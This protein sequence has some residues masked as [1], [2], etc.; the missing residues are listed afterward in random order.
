LFYQVNSRRVTLREYTFEGSFLLKPL[1]AFIGVITKLLRVRLPSSVDIPPVDSMARFQID[2]GELAPELLSEL[3]LTSQA[4]ESLGFTK[5]A[6][7]GLFD[8]IHNTRYASQLYF[9][10]GGDSI[11]WVRLRRWPQLTQASRTVRVSLMTLKGNELV[12]LT[13]S[14]NRDLLDP[15]A[16]KVRYLTRAPIQELWNAHREH[17]REVLGSS[18][19]D[20]AYESSDAIELLERSHQQHVEFQRSRGVFEFVPES[21]QPFGASIAN[22]SD[23]N[24][25]SHTDPSLQT[26]P[27]SQTEPSKQI[28]PYSHTDQ[29]TP[30]IEAVRASENRQTHRF[31]KLLVLVASVVLFIGLG[32][33]NWD[34]SLLLMLVPILFVHE[35]GHFIAMR[36]F[37]YRNVQMFFIPLFGA[38]VTG[39]HYNVAAWKKAMVSLAGPTP[40][41]VLAIGLGALAFFMDSELLYKT[42]GFALIINGLNLLPFLPLDGGWLAHIT[43]FSRS[44]KLDLLFRLFT[45]C[46]LFSLWYLLSDRFM[47]FIGIAM[48]MGLPV[49]WR[50]MRVTDSLRG[51][52]L[53]APVNDE[54]PDE[55][56]RK[57]ASAVQKEGVPATGVKQLAMT[58]INVY[59]SLSSP[60]PSW[61]ATLGIWCL[62]AGSL[63]LAVIG[64]AV[65]MTAYTLRFSDL[66]DLPDATEK[67]I[68]VTLNSGQLQRGSLPLAD[69]ENDLMLWQFENVEA[70]TVGFEKLASESQHTTARVDNLVFS[71]QRSKVD[72]TEI[73]ASEDQADEIL[74][75][76][77]MSGK[78]E[79]YAHERSAR[80]DPRLNVLSENVVFKRLFDSPVSSYPSIVYSFSDNDKADSIAKTLRS[81]PL[82]LEERR[83][84]PPWMPGRKLTP[85][86]VQLQ[87]L[88]GILSGCSGETPWSNQD[89]ASSESAADDALFEEDLDPE[90][91]RAMVERARIQEEQRA[92][93]RK[94][95]IQNAKER[96]KGD[97]LGMINAFEAYEEAMSAWRAEISRP[98]NPGADSNAPRSVSPKMETF[99]LP[100]ADAMGYCMPSDE[101]S[102]YCGWISATRFSSEDSQEH[103]QSKLDVEEAVTIYI[104]DAP[105]LAMMLATLTSWMKQSGA[106]KVFIVY[107][108]TELPEDTVSNE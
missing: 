47:L 31:T 37:G 32:L 95:W 85:E 1:V 64:G 19:G 75:Q 73:V 10:H 7:F 12:V 62:H 92:Q 14:A 45:L 20:C 66:M 48:L 83:P 21:Q 98:Q 40:S 101:P 91:L 67:H 65:I 58:T 71:S 44:S 107:Q 103:F 59:Q 56:I 36:L 51:E 54:I 46:C 39:H 53:P 87:R 88:F 23:S 29:W 50:T 55:A 43:L 105:D 104:Y 94:E 61:P 8:A 108:E 6:T 74:L 35:L 70:A 79:A 69:S 9:T 60:P 11:A 96:A 84:L 80:N 86:Q 49:V 81:I 3:Q 42:A 28:D 106:D 57:I 34:M 25:Y 5:A 97:A 76:E 77:F 2:E 13:T 68:S 100:F 89:D 26:E 99:L 22:T 24:P 72:T 93:L 27:S 63:V 4:L 33:A 17:I 52:A 41:I 78:E 30:V 82:N 38:A 16:W 15:P 90:K 102:R 18:R